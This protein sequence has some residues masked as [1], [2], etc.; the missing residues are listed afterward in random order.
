MFEQEWNCKGSI[1]SA[2]N[3]FY[4]Y[5]EKG[6]NLALVEP[7]VEEFKIISSFQIMDGKGPHWAHPV[8]KNGVLYVRHGEVLMAFNI[9]V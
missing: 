7:S 8:I 6:G 2:D 3:L 4:C 1:I 9:K 5:E